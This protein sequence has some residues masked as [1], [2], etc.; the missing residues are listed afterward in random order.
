MHN[1]FII[2]LCLR[3][4]IPES[5]NNVNLL[6][7]LLFDFFDLVRWSNGLLGVGNIIR[8]LDPPVSEAGLGPSWERGAKNDNNPMMVGDILG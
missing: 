1:K 6:N 8:Q 4:L 3:K 5:L 7:Y 2:L